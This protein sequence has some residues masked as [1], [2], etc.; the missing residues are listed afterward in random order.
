M[1][2]IEQSRGFFPRGLFQPDK[3]F[4]FS[5]DS[6][7]LSCFVPVKQGC[8]V[9][10]LGTGCAVISLGL[11]LRYPEF[12][13]NITGVDNNREMLIAANKNAKLLDLNEYFESLHL[14]VGHIKKSS[15]I[16]PE[17]YD[18]V[19]TNPPYRA[20]GQGRTSPIK[21]KNQACF[22]SSADLEEFICS[23]AYALK[24]KGIFCFVYLAEKMANLFMLVQKYGLEPKRI[25]FV[26]GFKD[27]QARL[28][29]L[30]TRK[31]AGPGLMVQAPLILYSYDKP[32][33]C[34]TE[35]TVAF[36]PFLGD[37]K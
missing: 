19:F 7:L 2:Q 34:L 15:L 33:N 5:V 24:N 31:N 25:C 11:C 29:L 6:L 36:C 28:V 27:K 14:D 18:L 4:R 13:F 26:H 9:L 30:E 32:G 3:G 35:E 22:E 1:S 12:E 17:S 23:G 16:K 37:K 10:D 8:K 20:L 21:A